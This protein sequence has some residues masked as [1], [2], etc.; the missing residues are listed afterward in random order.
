M[1]LCAKAHCNKIVLEQA[2]MQLNKN[3]PFETHLNIATTATVR[4]IPPANPP[5]SV[6]TIVPDAVEH[7]SFN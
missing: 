6:P 2:S 5:N 1:F 3:L 7:C 4:I